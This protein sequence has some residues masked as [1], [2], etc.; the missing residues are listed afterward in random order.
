LARARR[1][2]GPVDGATIALVRRPP[3]PRAVVLRSAYL[4]VAIAGV[5]TAVACGESEQAPGA[6][7]A[8]QDGSA[9]GAGG[10]TSEIADGSTG[11]DG[12]TGTPA[13]GGPGAD[14]GKIRDA[15]RDVVL[16][17]DANACPPAPSGSDTHVYIDK[18]A[19]PGVSNGSELCPF[20]SIER[21]VSLNQ[22]VPAGGKLTFHVWGE[23]TGTT[24]AE[25]NGIRLPERA[26]LTTQWGGAPADR[27]VV[28]ITLLGAATT[29]Q[30]GV[31]EVPNASAVEGFTVVPPDF[32]SIQNGIV[33]TALA[34]TALAAPTVRDVRVSG[35]QERGIWVLNDARL[36]PNVESSG[37]PGTGLAVDGRVTIVAAN[38][39]FDRNGVGVHTTGDRA[40]T[41]E[42]VTASSNTSHGISVTSGG[43]HALTDVHAHGN[44]ANGLTLG[45]GVL[46]GS[47]AFT[48]ANGS[49]DDN[50]GYGLSLFATGVGTWV[51]PSLTLTDSTASRNGSDGVRLLT[52]KLVRLTGLVANDNGKNPG[53]DVGGAGVFATGHTQLVLRK[54]RTLGNTVG[55]VVARAPLVANATGDFGRAGDLGDNV[56]GVTGTG[57]NTKAGVCVLSSGALGSFPA[58][59]N[60]WSAC[61]PQQTSFALPPS[62]NCYALAAFADVIY[63]PS[64]AANPPLEIGGAAPPEC[65]A[66]P[67]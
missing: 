37:N 36:G 48:V 13:D 41:L 65:K 21:A 63:A 47:S 23:A 22:V 27:D 42:G 43:T 45:G 33:A 4:F 44:G 39:H 25:P 67:P 5:R 50:T 51:G 34:T 15:G 11:L 1:S 56:L 2:T 9:D 38:N 17:V 7:G 57:N 31:L 8:G 3:S 12:S 52:D 28:T 53:A 55:V 66:G 60:A 19:N 24:Y 62:G 16:V 40:I 29:P 30:G 10:P 35:M 20:T 32:L 46:P 58:T 18:A 54:S 14:A 26:T 49:F 61:P 6:S 59:G 64:G